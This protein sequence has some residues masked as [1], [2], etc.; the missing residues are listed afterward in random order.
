MSEY[1]WHLTLNTGHGRAARREEID[2]AVLADLRKQ[3]AAGDRLCL[4]DGYTCV[5]TY[6]SRWCF[7][8]EAYS[9]S[10]VL[11]A[12]MWFAGRDVR[13]GRTQWERAARW[14]T[15]AVGKPDAPWL[16]VRIDE[17]A[18]ATD[19]AVHWLGDAERCIAW[20]FWADDDG[21]DDPERVLPQA[22]RDA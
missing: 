9:P 11:L 22:R 3:L 2:P 13:C 14:G 10:G 18:L 19:P 7:E 5:L 20:A 15:G 6:R 17:G 21:D 8:G 12:R 16:A 4:A 1:I